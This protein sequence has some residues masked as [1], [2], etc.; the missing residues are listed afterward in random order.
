[1]PSK[2]V[3]EQNRTEKALAEANKSVGAAIRST[4]EKKTSLNE[5]QNI[6]QDKLSP[7]TKSKLIDTRALQTGLEW[8]D[9]RVYEQRALFL[10]TLKNPIRRS[11]IAVIE[12]G[13]DDIS[14]VII[15][16]STACMCL[17]DPLDIPSL[18]PS[19]SVRN[20]LELFSMIFSGLFLTEALIKILGYGFIL[21]SKSYLRSGWNM[22]DF[23]IAVLGAVA[24]F[25]SSSGTSAIRTL[26]SLRALRP[27]R[28]I[29]RFPDLRALVELLMKV[30]TRLSY[31]LGIVFSIIYMFSILGTYLWAGLASQRCYDIEVGTI[32]DPSNVCTKGTAT[33]A[34]MPSII[35]GNAIPTGAKT[36]VY[37]QQCLALYR[38]EPQGNNYDDIS[39]SYATWIQ[40]ITL[41]GWSSI[42]ETVQNSFSPYAGIVFLLMVTVIPLYILLLFQALLLHTMQ[43]LRQKEIDDKK[44]KIA[45]RMVLHIKDDTIKRWIDYTAMGRVAQEN[46]QVANFI[47]M[48]ETKEK[49]R[50][51]QE[52]EY[53]DKSL[54]E[55]DKE[56]EGEDIQEKSE[57]NRELEISI[58]H[59]FLMLRRVQYLWYLKVT[60]SSA[61][62]P[63]IAPPMSNCTKYKNS[64][65]SCD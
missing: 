63:R 58:F 42:M 6:S 32:Y 55:L 29:S 30:T 1:M 18:I 33:S 20:V 31:L 38:G 2:S 61:S 49:L 27:L 8:P 51:I 23:T 25:G 62:A 4:G 24:D 60:L 26:R 44:W 11:A 36:C 17:G 22:L 53:M 3:S 48:E 19:S 40:F 45:E 35:R 52:F 57:Y 37:G 56:L 7:N 10:L 47:R 50:G 65:T 9:P 64:I 54:D 28:T 5:K 12:N 16:A 14:L 39:S 59:K 41:Q 15:I 13:L 46:K 34:W 43:E 21:G